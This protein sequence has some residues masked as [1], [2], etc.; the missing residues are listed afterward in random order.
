MWNGELKGLWVGN[1]HRYT[2]SVLTDEM[3]V[4]VYNTIKINDSIFFA[5]VFFWG[6]G[7]GRGFKITKC[8]INSSLSIKHN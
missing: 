2:P 7:T 3:R 8:F 1:S 6:G 4:E 5:L